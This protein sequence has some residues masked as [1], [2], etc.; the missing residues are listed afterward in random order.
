MLKVRYLAFAMAASAVTVAC[1][2]D[3]YYN[4]SHAYQ[5]PSY[6]RVADYSDSGRVVAIDVIGGPGPPTGAGAVLGGIVRGVLGPPV[7]SGPG[8]DVP[9]APG[10]TRGAGPRHQS[11]KR[12]HPGAPHPPPPR[13][14]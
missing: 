4:D 3:P 1:G 12:P 13:A 2:S 6:S 14:R 11:Q 8:N 7:C 9:A 5:N 10:P